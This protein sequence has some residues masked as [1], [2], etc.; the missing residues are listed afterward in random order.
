MYGEMCKNTEAS[1]PS[2]K[3]V[4]ATHNGMMPF[5]FDVEYKSNQ[6]KPKKIGL[7]CRCL[8]PKTWGDMVAC[9][10]CKL[11]FHCKCVGLQTMPT[12]DEPWLC[13]DSLLETWYAIAIAQ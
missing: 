12:S 11:W 4:A 5:P 10:V 13:N 1:T 2:V 9:D 7:Y 3:E 8:M 6:V